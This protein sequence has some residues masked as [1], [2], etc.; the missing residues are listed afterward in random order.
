[1]RRCTSFNGDGSRIVSGDCGANPSSQT[2]SIIDTATGTEISALASKAG[3]GYDPEWAPDSSAIA[4]SNRSN[5]LMLTPVMPGDQFGTPTMLHAAASI[6]GGA[7]DWHPTWSVDSKWIVFQ[8]GQTRRTGETTTGLTG[9]D[10]SLFIVNRSGG[11]AVRLDKASG[12][13]ENAFR[14]VFSPFDSGGYFWLLFT[15][16]RDYG[17]AAAGV[18]GQ[19]QIWVT[20]VHNNPDGTTDPSEVAYYLAGQE[21]NTALSP[22]WSAP[23]CRSNGMT[24]TESSQCCSAMC[25]PQS[26]TCVTGS[27]RPRGQS[28]GSDADCCS[29]YT[30]TSAHICD[31]RPTG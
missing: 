7:V 31:I 9:T 23:S 20:A 11:Q 1:V 16:K 25:D 15:T 13:Q 18:H 14:P 22:Y 17:N 24:C 2:F 21:P 28:C 10:G 8:H 4:Y 30:C 3:D 19:K 12:A 29:G 26:G 5:D 6:P 27:C